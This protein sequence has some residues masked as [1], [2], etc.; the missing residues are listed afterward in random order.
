MILFLFMHF[1]DKV[2]RYHFGLKTGIRLPDGI[3]WLYP[4][5]DPETRRCMEIFYRKYY[6]DERSRT[7]ILGINP[8]RFGAG[9]TGVPFTDPIRLEKLGI[10]NG[11]QK[12]QELSSVFIYDMIDRCGGPADFYKKFYIASLSPLGLVKDGLNYNYYDDPKVA[13][14][15]E[16]LIIR[17]IETQMKFGCDTQTVF[18]L[19]QGKNF[20]YL[21]KLNGQHGWWKK[22]V[23]LPHPRWIMQYRLKRKT[24]FLDLYE[25]SLS[26]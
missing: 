2:L 13:R 7:F 12:K 10:L 9:L 14:L 4:Y 5:D 26:K 22:V 21:D 8:G 16:P 17:N 18:C 3:E 24:E 20:T 19:G 23:P 15:V 6:G 11:F 1:G 25:K